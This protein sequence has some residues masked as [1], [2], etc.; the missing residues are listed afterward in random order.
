MSLGIARL[1]GGFSAV[2]CGGGVGQKSRVCFGG[3]ILGIGQWVGI[4]GGP[5]CLIV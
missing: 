5:E 1:M 3:K 4:V 2:Q